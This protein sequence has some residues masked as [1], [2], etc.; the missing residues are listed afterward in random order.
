MPGAFVL[1]DLATFFNPDELGDTALH[2]STI[3][4]GQFN[5]PYRAVRTDI[6]EIEVTDP[7]FMCKASD[8]TALSLVHGDTL[9][10]D[11]KVYVIQGIEPGDPGMSTL[12]LRP[13]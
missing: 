10:I 9:T 4:Y 13:Q 1:D 3:F 2:G 7:T 11:S 8:V 5:E 6:G 12:I